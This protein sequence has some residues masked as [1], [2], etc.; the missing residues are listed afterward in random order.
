MNCTETDSIVVRVL[1]G[2]IDAYEAIVRAYQQEVWKVVAA[3]LFDAQRTEDLVQKAFIN[4][5]QHLHQYQRG[6]D[7]GVWLK[8]IARNQVRQELRRSAREDHRLEVYHTH[9][10]H[11]YDAPA[12]SA[13]ADAL[14]EALRDCTQMLPPA[15]AKVVELRYQSGLNFGEIAALLGRTVAATRQQLARI[16]LAL[17]DC[18]EKHP[19]KL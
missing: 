16:R 12:T 8:E 13:L 9:L 14:A 5:Y 10:L 6:R 17:R 11:T 18:L 4:A 15:S 2:E 1:G 7:F 19:V 3:M